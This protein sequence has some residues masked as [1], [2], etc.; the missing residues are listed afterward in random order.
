MSKIFPESVNVYE[1]QAKVL[2]DYYRQTAE[3]IVKQEEEVEKKIAV[4][5]EEKAQ[6]ATTRDQKEAL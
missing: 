5:S 2:F 6:F 3:Q 1:D 4:A